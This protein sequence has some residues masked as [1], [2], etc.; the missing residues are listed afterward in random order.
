MDEKKVTHSGPS[1]RKQVEAV[2]ARPAGAHRNSA[3]ETTRRTA[4]A[5]PVDSSAPSKKGGE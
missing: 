3:A 1:E 4:T 2:R 5:K